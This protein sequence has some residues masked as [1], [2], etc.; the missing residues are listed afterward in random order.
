MKYLP[1]EGICA[2]GSVGE[3]R[4]LNC[5][6]RK[7]KKFTK[8][9]KGTVKFFASD[10][11]VVAKYK[12]NSVVTIAYNFENAEVGATR[13]FSKEAKRHVSYPQPII[14]NHY[15]SSM[16]VVNQMDRWVVCYRTRMRQKKVVVANILIIFYVT[17]VNCWILWKKTKTI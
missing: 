15:N 17:I 3:N 9:P 7:K 4:I 2:T 12:D 5:P 13:R 10:A 8:L 6:L 11:V 14:V 1:E 16:G